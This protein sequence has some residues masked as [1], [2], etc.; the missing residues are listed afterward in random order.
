MK[1]RVANEHFQQSG[2]A[3]DI[4]AEASALDRR[5]CVSDVAKEGAGCSSIVPVALLSGG[6]SGQARTL[7]YC[8]ESGSRGAVIAIGE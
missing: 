3:M 6:G 4:S 1:H 2:S 7:A 8:I 5:S